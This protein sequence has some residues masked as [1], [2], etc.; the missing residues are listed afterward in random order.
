[1]DDLFV[2]GDDPSVTTD[3][4]TEERDVVS[5]SASSS[6]GVESQPVQNHLTTLAG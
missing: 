6:S 5:G 3:F 4:E 1:M 2:I